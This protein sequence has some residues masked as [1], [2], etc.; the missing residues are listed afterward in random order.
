MSAPA[1]IYSENP[2]QAEVR[3]GPAKNGIV[4]YGDSDG[5]DGV[6][7][8]DIVHSQVATAVQ[9]T[10]FP[11]N[12]VCVMAQ[13]NEE[14]ADGYKPGSLRI[15]LYDKNTRKI[16]G[17]LS[18]WYSPADEVKLQ[19]TAR[20]PQL[21]KNNGGTWETL[22]FSMR[23]D[24][25]ASF[26]ETPLPP[27]IDML[28]YVA[29]NPDGSI[30][31]TSWNSP[32]VDVNLPYDQHLQ[33]QELEKLL[34]A[35]SWTPQFIDNWH[36]YLTQAEVNGIKVVQPFDPNTVCNV[37]WIQYTGGSTSRP[38]DQWA[39]EQTTCSTGTFPFRLVGLF[40][41]GRPTIKGANGETLRMSVI[42]VTAAIWNPTTRK[43][44]L[45][46]YA[47][48]EVFDNGTNT[49]KSLAYEG[50]YLVPNYKIKQELPNQYFLFMMDWFAKLDEQNRSRQNDPQYPAI[51]DPVMVDEAFNATGLFDERLNHTVIFG[52]KGA[53]PVMSPPSSP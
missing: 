24:Y 25:L 12:L 36:A 45:R 16:V 11:D 5:I 38:K 32:K 14:N 13:A 23:A 7:S 43:T 48:S 9:L 29:K 1:T 44:E 52:S 42:G 18:G 33:V 47:I 20:G 46:T 35:P 2:Q 31:L 8:N 17:D 27:Q 53:I 22:D 40:F 28:K 39:I 34:S 19:W 49:V 21:V 15:L 37:K 4:A 3:L 50:S 10:G 51:Y 6:S 26:T 30:V 41:D